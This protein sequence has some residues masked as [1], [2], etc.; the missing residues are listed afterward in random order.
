M[1]LGGCEFQSSAGLIRT[2]KGLKKKNPTIF[3]YYH[4]Y[5]HDLGLVLDPSTFQ[6][7]I[8]EI[9][10]TQQ[11]QALGMQVSPA[12]IGGPFQ[13]VWA[14]TLPWAAEGKDLEEGQ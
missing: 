4:E 8:C 9:P 11:C 14:L 5:Q 1:C 10:T 12:L 7:F 6:S 3:I 13:G 2:E